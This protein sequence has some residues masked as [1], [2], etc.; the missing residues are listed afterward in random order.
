MTQ[1]PPGPV[2]SRSTPTR[3]RPE[4]DAA[5]RGGRPLGR[6]AETASAFDPTATVS[7]WG[8]G[9]AGLGRRLSGLLER[10]GSIDAVVSGA[11][12]T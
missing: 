1:N 11:S 8:D 5:A 4:A 12:G 6:I 2:G 7:D 10:A 9:A 3:S